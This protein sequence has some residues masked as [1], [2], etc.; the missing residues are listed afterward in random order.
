MEK[1]TKTVSTAVL[2]YNKG[3][4][5]LS[6]VFNML[7]IRDGYYFALHAT[8]SSRKRR[9]DASRHANKTSKKRRKLFKPGQ[10]YE[11]AAK[12]RVLYEAGGFNC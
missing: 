12:E 7:D 6:V 8:S 5:E 1:N 9:M 3:T 11:H 2:E 4:N 10:A